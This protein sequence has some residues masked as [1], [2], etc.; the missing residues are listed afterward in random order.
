MV[1]KSE[2]IVF[3][4]PIAEISEIVTHTLTKL[5]NHFIFSITNDSDFLTWEFFDYEYNNVDS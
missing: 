2:K 5:Q 1:T 4:I 3:T